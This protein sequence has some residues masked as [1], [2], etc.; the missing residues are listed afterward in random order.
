MTAN[1]ILILVF[2]LLGFSMFMYV[3]IKTS[4][5]NFTEDLK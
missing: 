2:G 4:K 3:A 1:D 5:N